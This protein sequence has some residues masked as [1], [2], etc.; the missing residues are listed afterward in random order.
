MPRAIALETSGRVG[1][2]AVVGGDVGDAQSPVEETFPHGLRH[3]AELVAIVDRLVRRAGWSPRDVEH[4]YLSVGPGSFTGLRIAVTFAKAMAL[5]TGVKLVAVPTVRVLVENLPPA[6]RDAVVVLD[7]KRGQ[8]FT[9]AFARAAPGSPWVEREPA[10][11]DTL[12]A[13]LARAPRPVHLVGEGIPYHRAAIDDAIAAGPAGDIVVAPEPDWR[14][15]ASTVARLGAA[16]AAAHRF[17]DPLTLT[18][19]Y[20]RLPEA[21]EKW[22]ARQ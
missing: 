10:H 9:A 7:A 4:L 3:A 12:S 21:E 1:S 8:I 14:G 18:P 16:L 5:A 22:Q 20:V 13:M 15:R 2:V 19:L 17:A 11:L 6:A